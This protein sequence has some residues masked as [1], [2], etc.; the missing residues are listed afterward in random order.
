LGVDYCSKR[1]TD[2]QMGRPKVT[3]SKRGNTKNKVMPQFE[4]VVVELKNVADICRICSKCVTA[5]QRGKRCLGC[6]DWFHPKCINKKFKEGLF[7]IYVNQVRILVIF[8]E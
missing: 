3:K 8:V 7:L 4:K 5:A 2:R 6:T 1:E